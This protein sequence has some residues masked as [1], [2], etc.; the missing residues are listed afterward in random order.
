VE[1]DFPWWPHCRQTVRP[2]QTRVAAAQGPG[3]A[4]V[5]APVLGR[6]LAQA[7]VRGQGPESELAQARV[8]G[9]VPALE[10][11]PERVLVKAPALVQAR[12]SVQ[13]QAQ[14]R[15]PVPVPE[16]GLV[17]ERG[18]VREQGRSAAQAAPDFLSSGH[19][20]VTALL[21]R[22]SAPGSEQVPAWA[23]VS[24]Q[25]REPVQVQASA[26][27]LAWVLASEPAWGPVQ[28]LAQERVLALARELVPALVLA[29]AQGLAWVLAS[30]PARVMHQDLWVV[31]AA[32]DCPS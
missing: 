31:L 23:L 21:A 29:S 20:L 22:A 6:A 15:A 4:Q 9:Q 5:S 30:E 3:L 12:A 11:G 27:G 14:G 7:S 17:K 26:Q 19:C 10:R 1:F 18:Q 2:V 25:V 24:E 8:L 32:P 16:Q 13:A 28:G